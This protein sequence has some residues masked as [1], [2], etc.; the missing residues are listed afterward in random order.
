MYKIFFLNEFSYILLF[1]IKVCVVL[2]KKLNIKYPYHTFDLMQ[3]IIYEAS[4][5]KFLLK[6][7]I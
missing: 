3:K 4:W 1:A 7:V 5:L 6:A 2:E